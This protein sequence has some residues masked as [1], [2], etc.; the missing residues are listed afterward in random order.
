[1]DLCRSSN[2]LLSDEKLL[3]EDLSTDNTTGNSDKLPSKP[4]N[5]GEETS[6]LKKSTKYVGCGV[7]F[8]SNVYPVGTRCPCL[9]KKKKT[10]TT[11]SSGS[12][13]VDEEEEREEEGR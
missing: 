13:V 12:G 5:K 9:D 4:S 7:D 10:A 11:S 6:S 8:C 2:Q 3:G 1:M